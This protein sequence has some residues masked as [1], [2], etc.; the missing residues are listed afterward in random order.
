M[1]GE[2]LPDSYPPWPLP[3]MPVSP[4]MQ[5]MEFYSCSRDWWLNISTAQSEPRIHA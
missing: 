5:I 2:D 3:I 1:R 4:R